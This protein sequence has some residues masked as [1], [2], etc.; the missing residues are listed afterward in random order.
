MHAVRRHAVHI[1]SDRQ[2]SRHAIAVGWVVPAH[3]V[4]VIVASA[5]PVLTAATAR[6]VVITAWSVRS[7]GS[8]GATIARP[9]GKAIV[10]VSTAAKTCTGPVI[11]AASRRPMMKPVAYVS[12]AAK[13]TATTAPAARLASH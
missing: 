12:A 1:S 5:R 6:P 4:I 2:P 11:I 3:I 10:D 7:V 9:A 8:V 13:A